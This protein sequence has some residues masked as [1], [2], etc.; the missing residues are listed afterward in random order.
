MNQR[1]TGLNA[2]AAAAAVMAAL[3]GAGPAV[4]QAR[5]QATEQELRTAGALIEAHR[6][7]GNLRALPGGS[8]AAGRGVVELAAVL[9]TAGIPAPETVTLD[10]WGHP[11]MAW[12]EGQ[13]WAV[14][15]RGS[16][17]LLADAYRGLPE[18]ADSRDD[19]VL[20]DD[21]RF[22]APPH[23]ERLAQAGKQKRT[24][25]DMRSV[26]TVFEAYKIDNDALPDSP[27]GGFVPVETIL[28]AVQPIYIRRLP[29]VDGWGNPIWIWTDGNSYRIV[30][31]GRD[32]I[33]QQDWATTEGAGATTSFDSD[34]VFGDGEFRQWP[35]GDQS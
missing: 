18:V 5:Q 16:D 12:C 33:L 17:G 25:A 32:G 6:V 31:A 11:V 15:S 23:I 35:E 9:E 19:F 10:G 28:E 2:M 4:A 24:M 29:L 3:I 20:I 21:Q 26:A 7:T 13:E 8:P 14:I 34:I 1:Q 30:S 27:T 22:Y